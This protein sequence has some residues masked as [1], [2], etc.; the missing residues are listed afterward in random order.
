MK[1]HTAGPW[2]IQDKRY[3]D[4]PARGKR[5]QAICEMGSNGVRI[6]KIDEANARLIASAPDMHEVLQMFAHCYE[7]WNQRKEGGEDDLH[8][9]AKQIKDLLAKIDGKTP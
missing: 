6:S 1:K 4:A 8:Y 5:Y 3:I 7:K 2:I 9:A